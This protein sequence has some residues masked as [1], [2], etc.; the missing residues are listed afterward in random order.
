MERLNTSVKRVGNIHIVTLLKAFGKAEKSES[1]PPNLLGQKEQQWDVP[2]KIRS[3]IIAAQKQDEEFDLL[4]KKGNQ[5]NKAP[6]TII[7][8]D[9]GTIES[10]LMD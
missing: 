4:L 10:C 1:L 6:S 8:K 3:N 2:S 9:K 7:V 5:A